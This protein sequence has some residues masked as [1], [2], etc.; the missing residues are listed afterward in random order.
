[1]GKRFSRMTAST[2]RPGQVN[3]L[4]SFGQPWDFFGNPKDF[5]IARIGIEKGRS[6]CRP[7]FV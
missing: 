6:I 5:I 4:N 1:M 2:R 7:F 3:E